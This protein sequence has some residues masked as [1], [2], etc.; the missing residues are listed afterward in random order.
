MF[1]RCERVGRASEQRVGHIAG[2][3]RIMG[4][5]GGGGSGSGLGSGRVFFA[6]N[7]A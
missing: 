4:G 3:S 2:F 6:S 5:I 7:A 1:F